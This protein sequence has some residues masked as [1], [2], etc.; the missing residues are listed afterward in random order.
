MVVAKAPGLDLDLDLADRPALPLPYVTVLVGELAVLGTLV[1]MF[2]R[3]PPLAYE[4][5]WAGA[6]SM[7]AMQLYSVRRRVRLLRHLGPLRAWLDAHIFL[8]FQGY[9]LVAYHSVGI[10][11]NASL[12]AVNFALVTLIVLTGVLGRYLYGFLPRAR[13]GH[14]VACAELA[15]ALGPRALPPRLRRECRGL[16][17]LVGL[18]V[19]RRRALRALARDRAATPAHARAV[20]R[21]IALASRISA[22]EVAER[23]FARWTLLHRPLALVVLGITILHVLAHFAYAR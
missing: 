7:L 13:A 2:R 20:R 8:G 18:D 6:G 10:S 23:W 1:A 14:A 15:R 12:A 3:H 21:S 22:L 5:G 16:L 9:L 11:M 19:A 4:L 17:D